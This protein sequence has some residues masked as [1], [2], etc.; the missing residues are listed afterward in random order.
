[1][2][3]YFSPAAESIRR[4]LATVRTGQAS[5]GFDFGP[6]AADR[7][8][9]IRSAKARADLCAVKELATSTAATAH[10]TEADRIGRQPA[11]FFN[12]NHFADLVQVASGPADDP[13]SAALHSGRRDCRCLGPSIHAGLFGDS[14]L[15]VSGAAGA[16]AILK[17]D[18]IGRPS[19]AV[20]D[21]HAYADHSRMGTQSAAASENTAA[22]DRFH[23]FAAGSSYRLTPGASKLEGAFTDTAAPLLLHR[24]RNCHHTGQSAVFSAGLA[25]GNPANL[26]AQGTNQATGTRPNRIGRSSAVCTTR[27][28]S[29]DLTRLADHAAGA[30]EAR[31]LHSRSSRQQS[32]FFIP[33]FALADFT[34]MDFPGSNQARLFASDFSGN[35]HSRAADHSA[36]AA[37]HRRYSSTGNSSTLCLNAV[38]SL[39]ELRRARHGIGTVRRIDLDRDSRN[40]RESFLD[41]PGSFRAIRLGLDGIGAVWR[42][43]LDRNERDRRRISADIFRGVR[44]IRLGLDGIGAIWRNDLELSTQ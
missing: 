4:R 5:G 25:L 2:I 34:I 19:A 43:D 14:S 33:R 38:G 15:L 9:T 7:Q 29:L 27:S 24:R 10:A 6:A 40:G 13:I 44:S 41:A 17:A 28:V 20:L 36:R 32:A 22:T 23:R 16:A 18:R 42:N 21:C 35:H 37:A 3:G 11:E 31:A 26:A 1:L 39:A 8:S 12:R 30:A